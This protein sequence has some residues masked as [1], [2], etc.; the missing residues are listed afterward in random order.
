MN[1]R[2]AGS[3]AGLSGALVYWVGAAAASLMSLMLSSNP[4]PRLFIWMLLVSTVLALVP[5]LFV[6]A[7]DRRSA[8]D[9]LG[10]AAPD[11]RE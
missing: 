2:L 10:M 11:S 7:L 8:R 4:S 3:A 1:P 9:G 6:M 5:A